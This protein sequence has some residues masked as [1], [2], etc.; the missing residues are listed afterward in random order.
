MAIELLTAAEATWQL[1]LLI[2]FTIVLWLTAT[3]STLKSYVGVSC[4]G[5][6]AFASLLGLVLTA[7]TVLPYALKAV[8]EEALSQLRTA[9][10]GGD[11]TAIRAAIDHAQAVGVSAQEAATTQELQDA[12]RHKLQHALA[13]GNPRRVGAVVCCARTA[14]NC[15]EATRCPRG[16]RRLV[17]QQ[18][19]EVGLTAA[20][21]A[22]AE[23]I[24]AGACQ[25]EESTLVEKNVA[26]PDSG[27]VRV[28]L[29]QSLLLSRYS[30]K[31]EGE[32][33]R[34][35]ART[36]RVVALNEPSAVA[37]ATAAAAAAA[38]RALRELHQAT[39]ARDLARMRASIHN[40]KAA[41]VSA[42]EI[43]FAK[44]LLHI[45]EER[46]RTVALQ[47]LQRAISCAH[48]TQRLLSAL[49]AARAAG[50]SSTHLRAAEES[51]RL[52]PTVSDVTLP[53]ALLGAG[54][55]QLSGSPKKRVSFA[56]EVHIDLQ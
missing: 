36:G 11:A 50:V 2:L 10:A 24:L 52:S 5:L 40:A 4:A 15:S 12:L 51:L 9:V 6:F 3:W 35:T 14:V 53:S 13:R 49:K 20:E 38:S 47:A 21:V 19:K 56:A 16:S 28:H 25:D 17:A 54:S 27:T 30:T 29:Q 44:T 8:R 39:E 45:E 7:I 32:V 41:G 18:S 55:K 26:E 23:T 48:D 46:E 33:F 31:D 42:D 37:R 1:V 22:F 43:E 34:H